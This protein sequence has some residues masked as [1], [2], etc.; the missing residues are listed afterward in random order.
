M[1]GVSPRFGFSER[2]TG[3]ASGPSVVAARPS[4]DECPER[5]SFGGGLVEVFA[6]HFW[7]GLRTPRRRAPASPPRRSGAAARSKQ[8]ATGSSRGMARRGHAGAFQGEL[9]TTV[10][11]AQQAACS[12]CQRQRRTAKAPRSVP[13]CLLVATAGSQPPPTPSGTTGVTS[14]CRRNGK[15]GRLRTCRNSRSRRGS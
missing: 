8:P 7:H 12:R 15:S 4:T 10:I 6:S 14:Q 13:T 11:L 1:I 5:F 3:T 2:S 9:P